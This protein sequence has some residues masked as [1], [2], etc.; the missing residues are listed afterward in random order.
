MG[1]DGIEFHPR[2]QQNLGTFQ[3]VWLFQKFIYLGQILYDKFTHTQV[4][5]FIPLLSRMAQGGS[6]VNRASPPNV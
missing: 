3:E 4:N 5:K 1:I 6:V 2:Y